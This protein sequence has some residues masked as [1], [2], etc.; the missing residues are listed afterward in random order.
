[1]SLINICVWPASTPT[2]IWSKVE[3]LAVEV[4]TYVLDSQIT[5]MF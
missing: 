3:K 1:M 2:Y 5:V 4:M